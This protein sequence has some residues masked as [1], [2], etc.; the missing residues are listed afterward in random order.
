MSDLIANLRRQARQN[1]DMAIASARA[2]Y[3]NTL[4]EISR[5][6]RRLRRR[7]P[8][9]YRTRIGES[10]ATMTAIRAAEAVLLEGHALTL[11]ELTLE[12]Q[13]R[14]CRSTDHPR[15]VAHAIRTAMQYHRT[16]FTRDA[17]RRWSVI[18]DS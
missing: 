6:A 15:A 12:V 17:S 2:E 18:A 11:V 7:R 14:G 4:C 1:R 9:Y 8:R 16:R 10:Y 3:Q 5:L 13:S